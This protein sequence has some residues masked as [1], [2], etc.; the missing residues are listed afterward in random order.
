MFARTVLVGALCCAGGI[1]HAGEKPLYQAVPAW[2]APVPAIDFAKLDD[3]D[4]I[5]IVF[6]QQQRVQDGQVWTYV[7]QATRV[8]STQVMGEIGQVSLPWQPDSGDLIIHR[9][10]IIRGA[11]HLDLI[12][13]GQQFQVLQREEQLEQRQLNGT[14]T[15]TLAVEGLRVGDVVRMTYSITSKDKALQGN[16]QAMLSLLGD[17]MRAK[18]ARARLS[19]PVGT[20][21]KWRTYVEG[22]AP[23]PVKHG[24]FNEI[25]V[26]LP[27]AKQ[28]ELPGDAPVRYQRLQ[29][30][31]AASFADWASVSR[32][33]A[34]LY[35]TEGLIAPG[36]PLAAEVAKIAAKS[37]DPRVRAALALQLVQ[38]EVRYLFKGMDG[39]NYIPQ[40]PADTWSL[41]YGDCKAKTL[42]LLAVLRELGIEAE[43]VLVNS[44][45]GDQVPQR[46][47]SVAAFDH[48][49]VRATVNGKT[50]WLDGT[51]SGSRLAD[52]DDTP[53]FRNVLPVR[54]QG[55]TLL[56]L[57]IRAAGRPVVEAGIEIDQSAGL[58]LPALFTVTFTARGPF[59]QVIHSASSQANK[60]QLSGMV[61]S[62]VAPM[63]GDPSINERSVS[64][65]AETATTTIRASGI[66]S[67]T[68]R[69]SEGRYRMPLDKTIGELDFSPDRSR[70][71]W[72]DIP[73]AT[74]GPATL[75]YRLRV[76]L[77]DK[78]AGYALEGDQTLP[79]TIAGTSIVR[80]ASLQGAWA[81]LEDRI[82]NV[83]AEIAPGD[84]AAARAQV[85]LAK[86]RLLEVVA[87]ENSPAR[88]QVV[89]EAR[90]NGSFAPIMAAYAKAIAD[91]P[92]DATRYTNRASFLG[93]V[94]DWKGAIA[95]IDQAIRLAPTADL[96]FWR[97][98]M[99]LALRDDAGALADTQAGLELDPG[100]A[101]GLNQLA[102]LRFRKGQ[103]DEALAA[104]AGRI[105][106]G[107]KEKL[108]FV[109]LQAELLGEAGRVDEGVA[110]LDAVIKSNPGKAD[111]LNSRC[112]LKGTMNVMLDTALK[113]CTRAI[114]IAEQPAAIYDSRAMVYFRMGR[115]DDALADL[116]AALEVSPNQG[117]SL[118]LRGVI[119][120]HMGDK[121]GDTD[122]AGARLMWPRVDE[123][124]ARYGIKP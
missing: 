50:L 34:P 16:V 7:D 46:L 117:A 23:K 62:T 53:P 99:K 11:E 44:A 94:W 101:S 31:E 90:R 37:A 82:E 103:K 42:L 111:L 84:I 45:L 22:L 3:A 83:A 41:R 57:P 77:P 73:V 72:K 119:R 92:E 20:D 114:E 14:L 30:L 54:A 2:I 68:F 36:S 108:G 21:L 121:A 18:F 118:Y 59:G 88:W 79:P 100:S 64:Y 122:L 97:G 124:Y 71:A 5:L 12:A 123:D 27:L 60:E 43:P 48:V 1:A 106:Q 105:A 81:T 55:A 75:V 10:E 70:P 8:A 91:D 4:P 25:E 107:G 56:P 24:G 26:T 112:W 13:K 9:A 6:D 51:G 85:A 87:P 66:V 61:Q 76:R 96:Y 29:M 65:D 35:K 89:A 102:S 86:T 49:I 120:K 19:W 28:P 38:D 58:G 110:A 33:M 74:G 80:H 63:L 95:D 52:L 39:G 40:S 69:Q 47:P 113:D 32:V 98:R 15:A 17:P 109:T 93:G 116:N 104:V 67:P 78:G 115:M